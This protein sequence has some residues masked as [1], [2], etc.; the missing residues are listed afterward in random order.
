MVKFIVDADASEFDT[1]K[2]VYYMTGHHVV[3]TAYVY[4]EN[5]SN[6]P[7]LLK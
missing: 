5:T 1:K 2:M 6:E 3:E 4:E 7:P